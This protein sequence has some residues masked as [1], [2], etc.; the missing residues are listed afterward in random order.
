MQLCPCRYFSTVHSLIFSVHMK[1]I[2]MRLRCRFAVET[3]LIIDHFCLKLFVAEIG[4]SIETP[5]TDCMCALLD[6]LGAIV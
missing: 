5:A 3:I 6:Q 2:R 4:R 1:R